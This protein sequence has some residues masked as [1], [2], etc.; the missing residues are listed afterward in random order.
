MRNAVLTGPIRIGKTTVC[1]AVAEQTRARGYNVRGILTPPILDADGQRLG[2]EIVDL[3][4]GKRRALA[5]LTQPDHALGVDAAAGQA[6]SAGHVATEALEGDFSGPSVG[7]YQ[8]DARALQWGREIVARAIAAGCD[9]LIVD[10]I[11]RLELERSEGFGA[12]LRLLE[13]GIVL[14]S[15]LVVRREL[16][17]KFR[18]RLPEL[19]HVTFDISDDNR[20]TLPHDLAEWFFLD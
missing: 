17:D 4:T 7:V 6:G 11:G 1:Q 3:A 2:I 8:F 16:L 15:L 19:Q 20:Q 18:L 12:V 10:E 5:K 13:T 14:R 9:L